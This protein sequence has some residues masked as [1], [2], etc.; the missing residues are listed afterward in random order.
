MRSNTRINA[1]RLVLVS[2]AAAAA[3]LIVVA[4]ASAAAPQNTAVPTIAGTAREGQTLTASDGTWSNSP[5]SFSFQWQRCGSDGTGCGD[6]TGA[7]SKTYVAVIGDVGHTL[8]V[9]V[10][11]TNA[12]GKASANSAATDVVASKNGPTNTVKPAVSG[13]ALVGETLTVSNGTWTPTPTSFTRQWQRC[14]A[15]GTGCLNVSGASGQTYGIRSSDAGHRL[16]ALVTA[17]TSNGQAT[18]ASSASGT[19][20]A[21]TTTTT[22]TTTQT[23]TTVVTTPAPK[24]PTV[25]IMS[26]RHVGTHIFARFRVCSQNAG[27]VAI[28]ERDQKARALPFT[29]HL[30]V[31]VAA[32]GTFSRH[33]LLLP[34]YRSSGRLLVTM[35]ASS[36]GQLSRLAARSLFI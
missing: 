22:Q 9:V 29:R 19:V 8:R 3:G 34:R 21:N 15:D 7:T 28:T 6:I 14:A 20:S 25:H 36:H 5:T 4:G 30:A 12:D 16:R 32:C 23:T 11:A 17:H 13:S 10:T 27:R 31:T 2:L 33:W 24:A 35:R 26:L 18:A 1:T